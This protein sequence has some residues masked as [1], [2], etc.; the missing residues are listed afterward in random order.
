MWVR[1]TI[2]MQ[3]VYLRPDGTLELNP[4]R[5]A[6]PLGGFDTPRKYDKEF[7]GPREFEPFKRTPEAERTLLNA[8]EAVRGYIDA[9]NASTWSKVWTGGPNNQSNSLFFARNGPASQTDL[10]AMRQL[11]AQHGLP[12]A[13]D[14]GNGIVMTNFSKTPEGGLDFDRALKAK[15]FDQYGTPQRVRLDSGYVGYEDK[16]GKGGTGEA[17]RQLL[18]Y[19]SKTPELRSALNRNEGIA[20]AALDRAA[21]DEKWASR[22]GAPRE[23]IQRARA[24]IGEGAGW[25]DRLEAALKAG[26]ILP[27]TVAMI[28]AATGQQPKGAGREGL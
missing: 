19:V 26:V 10:L 22:W 18:D 11:G 24:I 20:Q 23:D 9:Q 16:W 2:P 15:V 4:G 17:T 1:P 12:D 21:R 27:A 5:V 25:I 3:G 7:V 28:F 13:Y 14:T 8:S 6:R